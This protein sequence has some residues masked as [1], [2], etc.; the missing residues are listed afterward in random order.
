MA[1]ATLASYVR[2]LVMLL[3]KMGPKTT[4]YH[5]AIEAN[6]IAAYNRYL[7]SLDA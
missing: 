5:Q 3:G 1:S 7:A 4:K 2:Q 6:L